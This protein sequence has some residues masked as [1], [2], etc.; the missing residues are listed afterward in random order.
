MVPPSLTLKM[1][2]RTELVPKSAWRWTMSCSPR[3]WGR[4]LLAEG[5]RW[6]WTKRWEELVGLKKLAAKSC[7]V[8]GGMAVV[9]V[10]LRL[11]GIVEGSGAMA[12]AAEDE[13]V[14]VVLAAEPVLILG[15]LAGEVDLVAGAAVLRGFHERL[16]D[17]LVGTG[18][19]SAF[20][21]WLLIHWRARLVEAANG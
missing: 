2:T 18:R 5:K 8:G 16:E 13:G 12:G 20:T 14:V 9:A 15:D 21:S 17:A 6:S 7:R 19:F 3:R 1:S 4:A 11:G 10:L